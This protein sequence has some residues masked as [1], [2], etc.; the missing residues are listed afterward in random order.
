MYSGKRDDS[1]TKWRGAIR[2]R[3]ETRLMKPEV[4][5][6]PADPTL[7]RPGNA[8]ISIGAARGHQVRHSG[9]AYPEQPR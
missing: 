8:P 6:L 7:E 9:F 3:G 4:Y 1:P 2:V 5:R